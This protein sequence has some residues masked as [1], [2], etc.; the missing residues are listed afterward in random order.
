MNKLW[1]V[2]QREYL[3]NVRKPGFLFAAFGMPVFIVGIMLISAAFAAGG[4]SIDDLSS[5][6]VVDLSGVLAPAVPNAEYPELFVPYSDE[7]TAR[8]AL[9]AGTLDAFVLVSDDY[10]QSGRVQVFSYESVPDDLIGEIG[11]LL[12]ANLITQVDTDIPAERV[13][14][15]LE[16]TLHINSSGR[17]LTPQSLPAIIFM[18]FIFVIVFML[19]VQLTSGFVMSGLV[20]EKTNRLIEVLVTSVTP[21]QLLTGKLIGLGMLGITQISVW[22]AMGIIALRV[23]QVLPFLAGVVIPLDLLIFSLIYFVLGFFLISSIMAV[24]GVIVGSEIE[25]RQYAAVLSIVYIVPLYLSF[26]FIVDANGTLPV[27]LSLIPFTAPTAMM[28]RLG[29]VSVPA[30]Q[31]A[32]SVG[33]LLVTTVLFAWASARIFRWALLRYGKKFTLREV[34]AVLRGRPVDGSPRPAPAPAKQRAA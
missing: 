27:V 31:V 33:I 29:F 19:A 6:G 9:D 3:T 13:V 22:L 1:L 24:I 28:M 15:P 25:S 14:D 2:T 21:M 18:P 32:L 16:A 20:E 10:A 26:S 5:V 12:V 30:W 17:D 34:I 11:D 4:A 8:A 7:S 23:G